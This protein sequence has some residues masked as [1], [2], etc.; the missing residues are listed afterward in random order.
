MTK[1]PQ[2]SPEIK[3]TRAHKPKVRTG[4]VTCKIR[5]VKCDETKP[6][7]LKCTRSGRKCDGYVPLKTWVFEVRSRDDS[8]SAPSLTS[9]P[10]S[11]YA[12]PMESRALM[13]FRERTVP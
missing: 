5:R 8:S 4:C 13:Y 10:S 6:S 11:D 1:L 3:R 9:S 12:D 7:C 2:A